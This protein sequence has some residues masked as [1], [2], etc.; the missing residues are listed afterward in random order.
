MDSAT[1]TNWLATDFY[2]L[3]DV[4]ADAT[5]GEI[6]HAYRRQVRAAHPDSNADA[7]PGR[8][9]Q[10]RE[11]YDVLGHES[12]RSQYDQ[13]REQARRIRDSLAYDRSLAEH[14]EEADRWIPRYR[15]GRRAGGVQ[16]TW[17]MVN[18]WTVNPW[19]QYYRAAWRS[20]A[21]L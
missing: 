4:R 1:M 12:R 8:F 17:T 11:A 20:R 7:V 15:T 18:P 9:Q 10:V 6:V 21:G 19:A 3:L 16:L 13:V 2:E 14:V 5:R